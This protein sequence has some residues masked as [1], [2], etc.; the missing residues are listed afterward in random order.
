[1][2]TKII[3]YK[4]NRGNLFDK[5][6]SKID[7]GPYSHIE[8]VTRETPTHWITIASSNRDGGVRSG[9]I[10]KSDNWDVIQTDIK[11]GDNPFIRY[12]RDDY[13]W[14]GLATTIWPW[15]PSLPHAWVCS[16]FVAEVLGLPDPKTYGVA[17]IVAVIKSREI[18]QLNG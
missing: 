3:L 5:L 9:Y 18:Q 7:G 16:S 12:L 2:T 15:F 13:D 8:I 4:A 6:V 14:P 11:F 10:P 17:D 1:M